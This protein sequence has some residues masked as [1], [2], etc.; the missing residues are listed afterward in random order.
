MRILDKIFKF[1][2]YAILFL[3]P[4]LFSENL[5][6][7]FDTP[8]IFVF[9]FFLYIAAIVF[10]LKI[11]FERKIDVPGIFRNKTFLILSGLLVFVFVVSTVFSVSPELSFFGKYNKQIGLFSFIN[12]C[13]FFVL[14]IF[15][16]KKDDFQKALWISLCGFGLSLLYGVLQFFGF[17]IGDINIDTFLGRIFSTFGH[18]NTFSLYIVTLFFPALGAAVVFYVKRKW[19]LMSSCWLLVGLSV[20]N[21][22]VSKGR[23][24]VL[25]LIVGLFVFIVLAGFYLHKKRLLVLSFI[26]PAFLILSVVFANITGWPY[27]LVLSGE[28]LRAVETRLVMWPKTIDMIL[29]RPFFGHGLETFEQSFG[30]HMDKK[31]LILE[32]ISTVPDRAHNVILQLACDFGIVGLSVILVSFFWILYIGISKKGLSFEDAF[33]VNAALSSL[34]GIFVA[35]QF[36]FFAQ[37]HFVFAAALIAWIL[38]MVDEKVYVIRF[39]KW[40]PSILMCVFILLSGFNVRYLLSDYYFN[41]GYVDQSRGD[42]YNSFKKMYKGDSFFPYQN[43]YK[44]YLAKSYLNLGIVSYPEEKPA[45]LD[46]AKNAILENLKFSSGKSGFDHLVLAQIYSESG[47]FVSAAKEFEIV[48]KSL[49]LFPELYLD[50]GVFYMKQNKFNEAI[51]AFEYYLSLC[52]DYWEYKIDKEKMA[53]PVSYNK[54]RI[55]FKEQPFFNKVFEYLVEAYKEIGDG[56]R[57]KYY[58]KF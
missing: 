17:Y 8:K 22:I 21:L 55:F 18:P 52:P 1:S 26:V 15:G 35:D 57:V 25:G 23:A 51:F 37:I 20:F 9:R 6:L 13:L 29:E 28:N 58:G 43:F 30:P 54:Y 27:R 31:L 16:F 34:I 33:F 5:F 38:K 47:D 42:F 39:G 4:L 49:P 36:G 45:I 19:L 56:E 14:L 3:M 10:L 11:F 24:S 32:S 44:L 46:A 50:M 40:M 2:I 41:S 7:G 53:D 48:K 12:Y